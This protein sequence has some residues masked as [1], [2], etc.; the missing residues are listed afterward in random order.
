[1]S[2]KVLVVEQSLAVRGVAE[3]LLR[4]YGFEVITAD[5]SANAKEILSG[6]K[7]DLILVSSELEDEPGQPLYMALGA[8]SS[9]AVIP[10]LVLHD[11]S[12]EEVP[13]YPPESIVNKPFTPREFLAAI[14]PF[15]GDDQ[16]GLGEQRSPFSGADFEEDLI[17]TAL[18]LDRI[19]VDDSEILEDDTAV[20]RK[21]KSKGTTE[22]MIGFDFKVKSG[23]TS[24]IIRKK[25]EAVN[26]P[27]EGEAAQAP[28]GPEAGEEV[29]E[30]DSGLFE[31]G[32][33]KPAEAP[34]ESS[35]SESSKLEI[36][37]DQY[38]L[39]ASGQPD[40]EQLVDD[41]ETH[42]YDWFLNELR[43]ETEGAATGEEIEED[44]FPPSIP[45]EH[46]VSLD[47]P[48]PQPPAKEEVPES[49]AKAPEGHSEAI[50]RF[51]SEFKKEVDKIT[52]DDTDQIPVTTVA[53][54]ETPA[55]DRKTA[56][57]LQWEEGIEKLPA[58]QMRVISQ[59]IVSIVAQ[60]VADQIA[61][62]IDPKVVYQ[63]IK[64]AVDTYI[65]RQEGERSRKS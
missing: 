30:E 52:G 33:E 7:F 39:I 27:A 14:G 4:Q 60:R 23:D 6:S 56:D 17:D 65:G 18:G 13:A 5:S 37:T 59:E 44:I 47:A 40:N 28:H 57:D 46:Q 38:G 24:K 51:I 61:A 20:Y 50:D 2:K 55:P 54:D 45:P 26:I 9:T 34:S 29:P 49:D 22:S 3:S 36:V 48:P 31:Q 64:D 62:R 19:E 15:L 32:K 21:Q 35:L 25:I 1:M 11:Q 8:D 10:L 43:K 16:N 53:P 42:D 63:L 58:D 41:T 12:N